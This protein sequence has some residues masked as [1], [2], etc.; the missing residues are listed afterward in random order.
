MAA[1]I[2]T[3]AAETQIPTA[4]PLADLMAE[5]SVGPDDVTAVLDGDGLVVSI[6]LNCQQLL[7][8]SHDELVGT[9]A[10][11]LLH[12]DDLRSLAPATRAFSQGLT[13]HIHSVQRLHHKHQG[14]RLV[15]TTL[16]S[17]R[18]AVGRQSAG[19]VVVAKAPDAPER[20]P[21]RPMVSFAPAAVGTAYAWVVEG[22]QRGVI[23]SADPVFAALVGATTASLVGRPLD[24]LTDPQAPEIGQARL[25]A[26]LA[27][28]SASYQVER[29]MSGSG[30]YVELT[31]SLVALPDKPGHTAVIQARDTTRQR[32]ADRAAK[33]SLSALERSNRELEAF[34]TVAA[35]DLSAP[36]RVVVGYA[37]MLARNGNECTPQMA[38]LLEKV[39]STSRRMQAQ[40]DGLMLLARV[41]DDELP[42]GHYDIQTLVE[43][44]LEPLQQEIA[45]Q[46][47]TVEVGT[48]PITVCNATGVV[49][50]FAN[51]ISNALKYGG[52]QPRITVDAVRASGAWQF[53]VADRGIGLPE[54]DERQLFELFERGA[55]V[56]RVAG[57][58][59]GLAVCRRI[60]TRHGGRIWCSRRPGGGAEFHFTLPDRLPDGGSD[61]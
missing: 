6:S 13:D 32:E 54:G 24:E 56:G 38:E 55:G 31:V 10:R 46:I 12:P 39:A 45:R 59:I 57:V 30:G 58:G 47:A 26:L 2:T 52:R 40:V 9:Y 3:R 16:R 48:L 42:T 5:L 27:G 35:H 34:A 17:T 4:L 15:E 11:A 37:E 23:A 61:A 60:V 53:T 28:S 1:Q 29:A 21:E 25:L 50:V 36:L 33:D 22:S 43:E 18:P 7:G 19:A 20:P 41:E 14:Y 51:L 8:Y 44:A 49:Q